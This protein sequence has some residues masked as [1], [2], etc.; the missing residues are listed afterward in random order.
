MRNAIVGLIIGIVAGIVL[1]TTVIAPRLK[2]A[3]HADG[4]AR[5]TTA[6]AENRDAQ[7]ASTPGDTA[8]G[9]AVMPPPPSPATARAAKDVLRL[10]MASAYPADLALHGAAAKRLEKTLWRISDGTFDLRFHPPGALVGANEAVDAVISGAIDALFTNVDDL[11][12]REPALTLFGGPP[13]GASVEAYLGWMSDGGGRELME[14]ILGDIGLQG[15]LC[16]LV[17][18]AAGGWFREA[19]TTADDFKGR[20]LRADGPTA[21][22]FRRLG[23]QTVERGYADTVADLETGRLY[24]AQISSP[25]VDVALGVSL[26]G[27][28]YYVP[29][30]RTPAAAFLLLM[31]IERWDGI[32]AVQQTRLRSACADN[33]LRAI[34][35]TEA[36]QFQALKKI[37]ANGADVR[38]W[39]AEIADAMRAAWIA[40]REERRKSDKLYDRVLTSYATFVKGQSIWE[41][42]ARPAK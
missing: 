29:G 37:V 4:A 21:A 26:T 10:R 28:V 11:A 35:G 16:G 19:M 1:G 33:V 40:E 20:R 25:H 13:M 17:P 38:P 18:N 6:E 32:G 41:E 14:D 36:L 23:A 3:P 22:L 5:S 39:P 34:S 24:G 12:K 15:V 30:W 8:A 9:T 31:P 42:L 7:Q 2:P 27:A